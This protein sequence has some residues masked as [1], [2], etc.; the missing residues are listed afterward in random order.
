MDSIALTIAED[1]NLDMMACWIEL[2]DEQIAA[3]EQ[4]FA[5][6]SL[7]DVDHAR[8]DDLTSRLH[9]TKSFFDIV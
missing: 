5:W 7:I 6:A 1:L 3:L 2:L 9:H 4:C 8:R